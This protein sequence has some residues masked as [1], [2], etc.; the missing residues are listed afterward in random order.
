MHKSLSKQV[1]LYP[2]HSAGRPLVLLCKYF[3]ETWNVNSFVQEPKSFS[4]FTW[5]DTNSFQNLTLTDTCGFNTSTNSFYCLHFMF[6]LQLPLSTSF[7]VTSTISVLEIH[8]VLTEKLSRQL[9]STL[10]LQTE[11]STLFSASISTATSAPFRN[12]IR[13]FASTLISAYTWTSFSTCTSITSIL[14][15][16]LT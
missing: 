7:S 10:T 8:T 16:N 3:A 6:T 14:A 15:A 1:I 13:C 5:N 12:L 9:Y 11:T 4:V 2:I